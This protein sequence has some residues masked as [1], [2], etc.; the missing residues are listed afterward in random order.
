MKKVL[1]SAVALLAFGFANAQEEKSGFKASTGNLTTELSVNGLIDNV[2][3]NLQDQGFDNEMMFKA[4][5]FKSESI[6][7]RG[8]FT[9]GV[10]SETTKMNPDDLKESTTKI[11]LG[12]GVEKHF[13]GT[14][15]LSPYVGGDL[16][17]GFNS[18]KVEQGS[19][20]QKGP[21]GFRVGVRG[22]FGAD[23]YFAKNLYLGVEAGLGIFYHNTGKTE[24][25]GT[26]VND[27]SNRFEIT[28]SVV[29]GVRVGFIMF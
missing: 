25:N 9:I 26:T 7:Y 5:Y 8:L 4:R 28:P 6:A 3:F 24:N 16:L 12:F 1:L 21:N 10:D 17:V 23:Y 11:G 13:A 22:V 15:R 14:D 20:E 27:G 19:N 18:S 2:S 29:G